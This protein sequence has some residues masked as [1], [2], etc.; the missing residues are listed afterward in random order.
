MAGSCTGGLA[1]VVAF[2]RQWASASQRV[3]FLPKFDHT[4][5]FVQ[6]ARP[7]WS[8][9][10]PIF[11]RFG[12]SNYWAVPSLLTDERPAN[13]G[14][15]QTNVTFTAGN[16]WTL[17]SHKWFG[18]YT[19]AYFQERVAVIPLVD[20]TQPHC[21]LVISSLEEAVADSWR[22]WDGQLDFTVVLH[23]SASDLNALADAVGSMQHPPDIVLY[24]SPPPGFIGGQRQNTTFIQFDVNDVAITRLNVSYSMVGG[25][26]VFDSLLV[27]TVSLST[28]P[29]APT[30]A[31]LADQA[32]LQG[33]A[34]DALVNNPTKGYSATAMPVTRL[35]GTKQNACMAG[36]CPLG[37]L[38]T[39]AYR[40]QFG[41]DIAFSTSGGL[42]GPGWPIGPINVSDIWAAM[43]FAN[44]PCTA[45]LL[46]LT[47]WEI[48][49]H[50]MA[51]A[52]FTGDTQGTGDRLLQVSGLRVTYNPT[53][54]PTS[55]RV[56]QI[57]AWSDAVQGY[58]PLGRL[59]TYS[60]A[61]DNFMC[62]S[63]DTFPKFFKARYPGETKALLLDGT[64]QDIL[65]SHLQKNSPIHPGVSGRLILTTSTDALRWRQTMETC[66]E[67]T[68]FNASVATC[69]ACPPGTYQPNVGQSSCLP[70][71]VIS[72]LPVIVAAVAGS[73]G[74]LCI[75]GGALLLHRHL[76]RRRNLAL[77]PHAGKV[78]FLFTDVK[79]S[80]MLW[81]L[82]P[83]S[84]SVALDVHH[85]LIRQC[86]VRH[87][88]YEVKTVGDSFM[89]AVGSAQTAVDLAMDIELALQQH[90]FPA[91]IQKIY[92]GRTEDV[93]DDPTALAP[94]HPLWNGLR[95]RISVHTGEPTCI[96]DQ[97]T[98]AWD[99]YGPDVNLAAGLQQLAAG[100]QVL[101]SGATHDH[102]TPSEK[103]DKRPMGSAKVKGITEAIDVYQVLPAALAA[104]SEGFDNQRL[105]QAASADAGG[106]DAAND[107][108]FDDRVAALM[109]HHPLVAQNVLTQ[110]QLERLMNAVAESM[111]A[112]TRAM[113]DKAAESAYGAIRKA[114]HVS[115]A[116]S[117]I[118]MLQTIALRV[119]PGLSR[120]K[121]APD[122]G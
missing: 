34:N 78:S 67:D 69:I 11:Q 71:P 56:T 37:N 110:G 12:F 91:A 102:Y 57:E 88:A 77:A 16:L 97:A 49:N 95:V 68:V 14:L 5:V 32:Y 66:P 101:I 48:M 23:Q 2:L 62:S 86:I 114:W 29:S 55:G 76:R 74:A 93:R 17:A 104:R 121:G 63:F 27:S 58:V 109:E 80:C 45:N 38:Y 42:R 82:A 35:S 41:A 106:M 18:Y 87:R 9:N 84:M 64:C 108:N 31:Y 65:A 112:V 119:L 83:K 111:L 54:S 122:C 40:Q 22:R 89:I 36:E 103:V 21:D 72:V 61:T 52:T 120:F 8:I 100:G 53:L 44:N 116:T 30:A 118:E 46:G 73:I 13:D 96:Q 26:A 6:M 70:R 25:R 85:R 1:A 107:E 7:Q 20:E 92:D 117:P 3:V 60:I 99:Y 4:S 90:A 39:D 113:P 28:L 75:G 50:S 105:R 59:R 33:L 15:L 115:S 43:P 98:L 81:G 51:L 24:E 10:I 19:R 47:V 94:L 79:S